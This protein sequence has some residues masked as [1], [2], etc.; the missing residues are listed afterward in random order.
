MSAQGEISFNLLNKPLSAIKSRILAN[1][2]KRPKNFKTFDSSDEIKSIFF[3]GN[4]KI[5]ESDK[6]KSRISIKKGILL[7]HDKK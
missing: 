1:P 7:V 4:G 6:Q 5:P 2:I 3:Q